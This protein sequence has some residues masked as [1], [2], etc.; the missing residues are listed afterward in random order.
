MLSSDG[1]EEVQFTFTEQ[2]LVIL[3]EEKDSYRDTSKKLRQK[4]VNEIFKRMKTMDKED[5]ELNSKKDVVQAV[6]QRIHTFIMPSSHR[7]YE[8]YFDMASTLCTKEN[9]GEGF[10]GAMDVEKSCWN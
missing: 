8:G 1:E 9:R 6:S 4:K 10:F 7:W 3:H 5:K 2:Q